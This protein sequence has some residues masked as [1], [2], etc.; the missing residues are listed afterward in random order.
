MLE[1]RQLTAY[2]SLIPELLDPIITNPS[3]PLD[4]GV[5]FLSEEDGI[6]I[7]TSV[8]DLTKPIVATLWAR[9]KQR[10]KQSGERTLYFILWYKVRR[11]RASPHP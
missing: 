11:I 3:T 1:G 7:L 9:A 10:F 8:E 4:N 2:S 6:R 5:G